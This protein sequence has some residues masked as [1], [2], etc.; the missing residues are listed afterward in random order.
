[1]VLVAS[2]AFAENA[3]RGQSSAEEE[4]LPKL[5]LLCGVQLS[6]KYDLASLKANN[7]DIGWD[8][9]SGSNEC[10]EP[11][12]ML[13]ELCKT[14][15]GKALVRRHELREVRCR[16][17]VGTVGKLTIS[18][19]V[20]TVERAYEE[21]S[22]YVRAHA[23][24]NQALNVRVELDPEDPYQDDKWRD[25]RLALAPVT[26]TTDY[27]DVDGKR[28]KY[29]PSAGD[30]HTSVR[31]L[32]GGKVVVD[33]IVKDRRA[34]GLMRTGDDDD[35][36]VEHLV[37]GKREGLVEQYRRGALLRQESMKAGERQ[38]AKEFADDGKV[39]RYTRDFAPRVRG[40]LDLLPD[41]RPTSLRCVPEARDDELLAPWCGFG[42]E[43]RVELV[44]GTRKVSRIVTH[45]DGQL[46]KEEPGDSAYA[47]RRFA[48]F[49]DGKLDG[50]E[51]STRKDGTLARSVT[52]KLGVR[53][54][55][56]Q[57]YSDDGKKVV[58][59][60][61]WKADEKLTSTAFFLNGNRKEQWSRDGDRAAKRTWYDLGQ[62]EA[63]TAYVRCSS[64]RGE[65]CES[66]VEKS[67]F[68]NGKLA[69]ETA[70]QDGRRNGDSRTWFDDG[71]KRTE[72]TWG[73]G[74][75]TRLREW[76]QHGK[77]LRDD[78]FEADGSR[79]VKQ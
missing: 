76:D 33:F 36:R 30:G 52:W 1:M 51:R 23:Q 16:G 39:K 78:E 3:E 49:V 46:V 56:E 68:E 42:K 28:V 50:E 55:P 69:S 44:D 63:E 75:R 4:V 48:T 60:V 9:T 31:C 19:G 11:L 32:H 17:V 7:K 62:L 15:D 54:G 12:R 18:K 40:E 79:K 13:W 74:R 57:E 29:D 24:F 58:L 53:D 77:Q 8:Q 37:D 35:Y 20:I 38:W 21:S 73:D 2:F 41:G 34:T 22:P 47:A 27:C 61:D 6:V 70:W 71:S 67:W 26:S 65:W 72:E 45:R 10:D 59:R 5:N 64:S 14:D 25:F 66:G 43:R